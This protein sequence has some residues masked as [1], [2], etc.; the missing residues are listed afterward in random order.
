[1]AAPAEDFLLAASS[2]FSAVGSA[3][4]TTS[5]A[6]HSA[7]DHH[8]R[9]A[10]LHQ[11]HRTRLELA[12][13]TV[14]DRPRY[15]PFFWK[16]A[17]AGTWIT[18]GSFSTW[19]STSASRPGRSSTCTCESCSGGKGSLAFFRSSSRVPRR[20]WFR[21]ATSPRSDRPRR[22]FRRRRAR[23]PRPNRRPP[24]AR[25]TALPVAA[26]S[27][28]AALA[29]GDARFGHQ[30]RHFLLQLFAILRVAACIFWRK[31]AHLL[32]VFVAQA[33]EAAA[34]RR[35]PAHRRRPGRG[36][37]TLRRPC[38]GLLSRSARAPPP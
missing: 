8:H 22:S 1:M 31:I 30:V 33:G 24:S 28:S 13:L 7:G 34:S 15:W 21:G 25:R 26:A 11:L 18:S 5:P 9:F 20:R 14:H 32:A 36:P 23:P 17:C 35:G 29:R 3:M 2:F 38:R 6:C 12:V 16:T 4:A 27:L 37:A 19:I 10:L